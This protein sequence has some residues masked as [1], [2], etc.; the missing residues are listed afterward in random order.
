M[1]ARRLLRVDT[2]R[3]VLESDDV[4]RL[5]IVVWLITGPLAISRWVDGLPHAAGW[6]AFIAGGIGVLVGWLALA[7]YHARRRALGY[8]AEEG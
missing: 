4:V 1:G 5:M 8:T 2:L 6:A 7:P 3:R